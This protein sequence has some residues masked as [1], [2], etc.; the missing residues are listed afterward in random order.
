MLKRFGDEETGGFYFTAEG[1]ADLIV[2][3]KTATDSPLPSG[4]AVAAMV[5]LSL[6]QL[7]GVRTTLAAFAQQMQDQGEAMS[8]MV[9]AALLYLRKTRQPFTVSAGEGA[10]DAD[11]P[12]S[13]QQVAAGVVSARGEWVSP[14]E[15]HVH[16]GILRGFHI[17]AHEPAAGDVPLIP[18]R[19][20]VADGADVAQIDYPPGEEQR[21]AFADQAVR[22]Y[23]G[24]VTI[25]IRF[26]ADQDPSALPK[27][28]L[29]YQACD[30][31]ACL[32]PVTKQV[33]GAED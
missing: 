27:L 12:L 16:L 31:S 23:G 11:R 3:Q 25:A 13:P 26:L 30:D 14:R 28:T 17:N 32:P 2:R 22:V 5:L 19:L 6:G 21:F 10:D 18:T 7:D 29:S 33:G 1:A 8:S 20:A 4:N 9:Q 24:N 15:L